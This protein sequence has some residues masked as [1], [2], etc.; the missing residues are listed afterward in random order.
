MVCTRVGFVLAASVAA[1]VGQASLFFDDFNSGA[2]ALWGNQRGSWSAAGGVYDSAFPSNAPVTYSDVNLAL[3]DFSVDVDINNIQD[4]GIWLRSTFG[5]GAESGVLLVTGGDLLTG[6]G[7]YWHIVHNG[8]YSG[9]MGEVS[10]LFSTGVSDPHLHVT[11]V[12]DVYSV[13]VNG[14]PTAATSITTSDFATG[15]AGVYDFS[16]Q[17]FD[18]FQIDAVPEPASLAVLAL[19]LSAARLRRA[20]R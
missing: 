13:Y 16:G 12:G 5:G 18:N 8:S 6:T 10:G 3:T 1:S 14:S 9:K 20:K 19:G 4:G 2:S 15:R 11:V 7:L 17:T